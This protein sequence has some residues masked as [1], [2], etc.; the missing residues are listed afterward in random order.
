V[1]AIT[2]GEYARALRAG[3]PRD[4][5][6]LGGPAH[7]TALR[8]LALNMP[9]ALV[10]LDGESTWEAWLASGLPEGTRFLVRVNPRLDP[11][12]HAHLATGAEE[13]KFGITP[14]AA[15]ALAPA[16]DAAGVLAGFHVHA[17][18]MLRDIRVHEAVL[19]ALEPLFAAFPHARTL[20]LGG[21]FAVPDYDFDALAALVNPWVAARGLTLLL[22]P[23][24]LLVAEAGTLLTRVQ[25]VK[26]GLRR[27]VIADAGMADLVRPALY[28]SVHP[29]RRVPTV[30][31]APRAA[32]THPPTD[33]DGPLCENGDRLAQDVALDDVR[34]GDL[35]AVGLAGAYGWTMGSHYASHTR[36]SEVAVQAGRD[37][38]LRPAERVSDLW[39]S[40]R[41]PSAQNRDTSDLPIH[42]TASVH[43]WSHAGPQ[44]EALAA[45]FAAELSG[46]PGRWSVAAELADGSRVSRDADALAPAAS[47]IK[48]PLLCAALDPALTPP[49][50]NDRITLRSEDLATGSGVLRYLAPGLNP[51]WGDLLTL[52]I[53]HSD[54]LA[55]N[56]VLAQLG[57]D[58]VNAWAA[59]QGLTQTRVAGPLQ[60]DPVRWTEAQKRGERARTTAAETMCIT[61]ALVRGDGWLDPQARERAA[62]TLQ[63]TAFRDG[64]LRYASRS[65]G[66]GGGP[67]GGK[68][69]WISGVRHEVAVWWAPGGA[70]LG[71]LAV[72][73]FEQPNDRADIDHPSLHALARIG[74]HFEAATVTGAPNR[75]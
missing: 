48:L 19:A 56:V 70:W 6:L 52:M 15:L 51:T 54:N 41:H 66:R 11:R 14:E 33:V 10:S 59:A 57:V 18:S 23:G 45:A 30:G 49:D 73:N 64:L 72:L 9:P 67:T 39:V 21:G 27:H 34:R 38:L 32:R 24:R 3:I 37:W 28:G 26:D 29:V 20:D 13:S 12:T 35:L 42:S 5:A 22:E 65:G 74:Q 8:T 46:E 25:H 16:V 43:S 71:T 36:I 63:A 58:A 31:E 47:L 50:W 75:P 53:A 68:G 4:R 1:E 17:G 69:G 7:D 62:S 2:V 44:G 55:T 60:V 40:E 61:S